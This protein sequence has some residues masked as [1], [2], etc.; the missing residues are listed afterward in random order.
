[1]SA[2]ATAVTGGIGWIGARRLGS[3]MVRRLLAAG[4]PVTVWN[5]TVARAEALGDAGANV[6]ADPTDLAGCDQVF[7][8][9]AGWTD[10]EEV[11]LGRIL[12][13]KRR[14]QVIVD[15]PEPHQKSRYQQ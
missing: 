15:T 1:V 9:L 13:A 2:D 10:L 8:N 11:V 5:R 3:A 14:P 12:T 6:A 7:T 4:H